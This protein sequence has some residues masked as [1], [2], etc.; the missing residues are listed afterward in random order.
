MFVKF[1]KAS[2]I[3]HSAKRRTRTA[4][5]AT[6]SKKCGSFEYT[7][8]TDGKYLYAAVRACT[9]DVP[10]LN[11]DMLPHEELKTAYKSFI[12]ASIFLNHDNT[13]PEKARGAILDAVYHDED[14]EDRWIECLM[15][16]DEERC[17]KLCSLL[18]SGEIDTF[19]MGCQVASTTCSVCGNEAEYP[20]EFC[21]HIQQK[22][23]NFNGTIAYEICNGIEFFELSVVYEP[24][25]PTAYTQQIMAS[26]KKVAGKKGNKTASAWEHIGLDEWMR[27]YNGDTIG[28]ILGPGNV[29]PAY[30][31]SLCDSFGELLC[32]DSGMSATLEEAMDA[33]DAAWRATGE[34]LFAK[35]AVRHIVSPVELPE[36]SDFTF[37]GY[38]YECHRDYMGKNPDDWEDIWFYIRE[39]PY[40]GKWT[41]TI[42]GVGRGPY[43]ISD[44]QFES[45]EEAYA[46]MSSDYSISYDYRMACDKVMKPF[47]IYAKTAGFAW[48]S[49]DR[50]MWECRYEKDFCGQISFV[51]GSYKWTVYQ[52]STQFIYDNGFASSLDESKE[53]CDD[54][55]EINKELFAEASNKTAMITFDWSENPGVYRPYSDER[56]NKYWCEIYD[57]TELISS[58]AAVVYYHSGDGTW[59]FE[60]GLDYIG[61]PR[62]EGF[63]TKEEAMLSAV[64][65]LIDADNITD[66]YEVIMNGQKMGKRAQVYPKP[67]LKWEYGV[68]DYV[69]GDGGWKRTYSPET[70][71]MGTVQFVKDD[72]LTP[73]DGDM[74]YWWLSEHGQDIEYGTASNE[75]DAKRYCDFAAE[76]YLTTTA[77]KHNAAYD[78]AWYIYIESKGGTLGASLNSDKLHEYINLPV[79]FGEIPAGI[80]FGDSFQITDEEAYDIFGVG[81]TDTDTIG[82]EVLDWLKDSADILM[83]AKKSGRKISQSALNDL[84]WSETNGMNGH[85]WSAVIDGHNLDILD[86]GGDYSWTVDDG[87]EYGTSDTL[88]GAKNDAY[89]AYVESILGVAVQ[90]DYWGNPIFASKKIAAAPVPVP[91][92]GRFVY[93]PDSVAWDYRDEYYNDAGE[94]LEINFQ[95]YEDFD[96]GWRWSF[97]G[98]EYGSESMR[99]FSDAAQAYQDMRRVLEYSPPS[100][101]LNTVYGGVREIRLWAKDTL[102]DFG[103]ATYASKNKFPF[104][105]SEYPS[106]FE[107]DNSD[108]EFHSIPFGYSD[109]DTAMYLDQEVYDLYGSE[110]AELCIYIT[111]DT[112]YD[113]IEPEWRWTVII[114]DEWS[115]REGRIVAKSNRS[116]T[117]PDEAYRDFITEKPEIKIGKAVNGITA[118]NG[119][120]ISSCIESKTAASDIH[121]YDIVTIKPEWL[122]PYETPGEEY[123]VMCEPNDWGQLY[124]QPLN[125]NWE[126]NPFG[127]QEPANVDQLIP[128][129]RKSDPNMKISSTYDSYLDSLVSKYRSQDPDLWKKVYEW[130]GA[131]ALDDYATKEELDHLLELFES[132]YG[133]PDMVDYEDYDALPFNPNLTFVSG[134]AKKAD[135]DREIW[136]GWTPRDFIEELEPLVDMIMSGQSWQQPFRS[137]GEVQSWTA[138]NQPYYKQPVPEVV[139]YFCD[140][141]HIAGKTASMMFDGIDL[142]PLF[143]AR[144]DELT[145]QYIKEYDFLYDNYDNVAGYREALDAGERFLKQYG[146]N[147]LYHKWLDGE[148]LTSDRELA[149][150]AFAIF[151]LADSGYMGPVAKKAQVNGNEFS[152]SLNGNTYFFTYAGKDSQGGDVYACDDWVND[153]IIYLVYSASMGMWGNAAVYGDGSKF[154]FD[155][156]EYSIESLNNVVE[157]IGKT[158][159]ASLASAL[160]HKGA[161]KAQVF[162]LF[163]LGQPIPLVDGAFDWR[164]FPFNNSV[165][166]ARGYEDGSYS[167]CWELAPGAW[168]WEYR[169]VTIT[170]TGFGHV[171]RADSLEAAMEAADNEA[172]KYTKV[173]AD[174]YTTT[175]RAPEEISTVEDDM[176][177]PLC[178]SENFDG[179]YCDVCG[180]QEPPEGFDDIAIEHEDETEEELD[181][182]EDE[183]V[184]AEFEKEA[185]KV[186]TEIDP[187]WSD[188]CKAWAQAHLYNYGEIYVDDQYGQP[189][190]N[191]YDLMD[192]ENERGK[193]ANAKTLA[194]VIKHA[195]QERMYDISGNPDRFI[196]M[197]SGYDCEIIGFDTIATSD[198]E[199]Q[200]MLKVEG[201][202]EL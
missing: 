180:Y 58:G 163:E 157:G 10:N 103:L 70:E 156:D 105:F 43:Y 116:F 110:T 122:A 175:D 80:G 186:V 84:Q 45:P 199:L 4:K 170:Y 38:G 173:A 201:A 99:G 108:A 198:F 83:F 49:V 168:Q 89:A 66:S 77:M 16:F 2:I 158:K 52:P 197:S 101:L 133:E 179:E 167:S 64:Q 44:R 134:G 184:S 35:K 12:G 192:I 106:L 123:V 129:R 111:D 56:D 114:I 74:W 39:N 54:T 151:E 93:N 78:D 34:W 164:S 65:Y 36:F 153:R 57:S 97:D 171:G 8:N 27:D 28:L 91:D 72:Y 31:W 24:A 17:P 150:F 124:M 61:Y 14:P 40:D 85:M 132:E 13:D 174:A 102:H 165:I 71:L 63:S 86:D 59:E 131:M 37:D 6:D 185:Y 53:Y 73:F 5:V 95:I 140:K 3:D 100:G 26:K 113:D 32:H 162:D 118:S 195:A 126:L 139:D 190:D 50:T 68:T 90:Y 22:G 117:T 119:H 127:H 183:E 23:H 15:E 137:R 128:T 33:C 200:D 188:Y 169:E 146:K 135:L 178:G 9:A 42:D 143:T 69:S 1:S 21:E 55:Y 19:S 149:A 130:D 187:S 181:Q 161:K 30:Q 18:R 196:A 75:D 112:G 51:D 87:V 166:Y 25:D 20:Y 160:N 182:G 109:A 96:D 172:A 104:D 193:T 152:L 176:D 138:D 189:I 144:G 67:D 155:A 82:Y 141:Y 148:L 142:E 60:P 46:D 11:F 48:E 121:L 29:V 62:E 115:D 154:V 7:P 202:V 81:D 136:E 159:V 107:W 94:A 88:D 177:C 79:T 47:S 41:W 98:D 191:E 92:F 125:L 145:E 76:K 120:A 194:D 147:E